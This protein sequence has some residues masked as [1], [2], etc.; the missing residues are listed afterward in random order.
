[1]IDEYAGFGIFDT[2]E[3]KHSISHMKAVFKQTV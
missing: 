3:S 1:V 2:A